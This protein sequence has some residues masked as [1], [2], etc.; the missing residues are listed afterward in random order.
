ML[1]SPRPIA[2]PMAMAMAMMAHTEDSRPMEIPDRT[3]V[4]GPVRADS[5]ISLHRAALGR[6]ELLGDLAGHQ[7]QDH[8][9]EHGPEDLQVVH[10]ELGHEERR[11]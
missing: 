8:A 6:G 5:A 7:R 11:R 3:V 1:P 2:T 9:G 10:V 4:A